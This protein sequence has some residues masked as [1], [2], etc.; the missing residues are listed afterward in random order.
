MCLV[1]ISATAL[2][3]AGDVVIPAS[4]YPAND[5]GGYGEGCDWGWELEVEY[6]APGSGWIHTNFM[7]ISP[8]PASLT[9]T[10]NAH[11]TQPG[12]T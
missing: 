2:A 6:K 9:L 7:Y 3:A 5:P 1:T 11:G 10:T 12:V 8:W 4:L